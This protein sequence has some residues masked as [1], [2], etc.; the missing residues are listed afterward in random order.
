MPPKA[1]WLGIFELALF[2]SNGA[3][4][5]SARRS[6]GLVSFSVPVVIMLLDFIP[7]LI[8]PTERLGARSFTE[9]LVLFTPILVP[10][11]AVQTLIIFAVLRFA[12]TQ[13]RFWPTIGAVNCLSLAPFALSYVLYILIML[14]AHTWQELYPLLLIIEFYG[15]A[16]AAFAI[17]TIGRI[18]WELAGA[19]ALFSFLIANH[20]TEFIFGFHGID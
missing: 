19:A 6:A 3:E 5:I 13:E 10:V 2:I 7:L 18:P 11:V 1:H 8:N 4:R 20:I 15:V 14:E 9:L 12:G 17:T 16:I